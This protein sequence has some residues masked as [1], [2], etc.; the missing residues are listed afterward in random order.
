MIEGFIYSGKNDINWTP[1]G[2]KYNFFINHPTN[3]QIMLA[4]L[5]YLKGCSI[6]VYRCSDCTIE[7]IDEKDL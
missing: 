6:K 7:I 5:N 4:K 1:K 3:S 2:E